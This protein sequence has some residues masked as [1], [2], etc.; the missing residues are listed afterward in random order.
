MK[1]INSEKKN[2]Y[3]E[4]SK[5]KSWEKKRRKRKE[6]EEILFKLKR[7]RGKENLKYLGQAIK[8]IELIF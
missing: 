4:K 2:I 5:K 6:K 3:N 7:K 8:K 1:K